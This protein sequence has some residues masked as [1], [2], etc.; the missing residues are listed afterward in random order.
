MIGPEQ[1]PV[2]QI[3]PTLPFAEARHESQR[4]FAVIEMAVVHDDHAFIQ[5]Q[6][7]RVDG[8]QQG[9]VLFGAGIEQMQLAQFPANAQRQ[10]RLLTQRTIAIVN[11]PHAV[12]DLAH[13]GFATIR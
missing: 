3:E 2:R 12:V 6:L 10:R 9:M 7:P 8:V 11:E 1:Q 4:A 5:I 13:T